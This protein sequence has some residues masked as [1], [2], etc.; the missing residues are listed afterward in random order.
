MPDTTTTMMQ[1]RLANGKGEDFYPYNLDLEEGFSRIFKG[2]LTLLSGKLYTHED[3]AALLD[4]S[5]SLTITQRLQDAKTVRARYLHGIVTGVKSRGVFNGGDKQD[6]YSYVLT[7][8]PALARLARSRLTESFYRLSPPEIIGKL[9]SKYGV[10]AHFSREY[11]NTSKYCA[12]LM[13]EQ[14]ETSDLSFIQE[15]LDLY[16][17]SF[18]FRHPKAEKGRL[19]TEELFFSDGY[20]YPISDAD[21]SDNRKIPDVSRFD[22]A[23]SNEGDNLWKMDAWS[24]EDGIGVDGVELKAPYPNANYGS[25]KWRQGKTAGKDRFYSYR[26]QFHGYIRDAV[27]DE[28]DK[29][30]MYILEARKRSLELAK[31]SWLGLAPN[32]LL[33]PGRI[34]ELNHYYGTRNKSLITALV[35]A[36][37][38]HCRTTWPQHLAV[39]PAEVSNAEELRVEAVCMNYG[40]AVT[41]KRFCPV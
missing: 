38:L 2:T 4:Q 32:L 11:I 41:D 34:F 13:F 23:F 36:I 18:T 16:G 22:A 10:S 24:M 15:L 17:L 35:T 21:Y 30:I 8:E 12:K 28:I 31:S 14:N 26:R 9:L 3:L 6:C 29:D 7:I 1:V 20:R 40:S 5:L 39:P 37:R 27:N 25:D 19:G 33:M